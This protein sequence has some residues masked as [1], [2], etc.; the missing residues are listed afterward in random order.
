MRHNR[1]IRLA[2]VV[3]FAVL[4]ALF[5]VVM[6][7]SRA[8]TQSGAPVL[9]PQTG[10]TLGYNFRLAY[11]ALGGQLLFGLPLTEVFI[12]EGMPVQ[13][14]ERVRLEWHADIRQAMISNLGQRLTA[15][16]ANEA[17]FVRA[18]HPG[19]DALYDEV[20]GHAVG[21]AFRQ[22]YER[23]GGQRIFGRPISEEFGE[24]NPQDGNNY[25]V[26]YFERAR[27]EFHPELAWPY[28]VSLG[29]LGRDYLAQH[30]A[31]LDAEQPASVAAAA[32]QGVQ[33]THVS[34]P[35]IGVAV[36]IVERG[37]TANAW[38]VPN[39]AAAHFWPVSAYPGTAGN[40]VVGGHV[41]IPG[42]IF[43]A[44]PRAI[45][46]DEVLLDVGATQRRYVVK[47]TMVVD[48]NALWVMNPSTSE[49]LTLITCYPGSNAA[50]R[51]IVQAVPIEN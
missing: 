44:L 48:S 23:Y 11:D 39:D 29:H 49:M 45:P 40:I 18:Q 50:E 7:A 14:F 10:H 43:S 25:T 17:P 47:Q 15:N 35:R 24:I 41:E 12:E 19:A 8:N 6:P 46:G 32:W 28:T 27:F 36:N 3:L 34:I 42:K 16:R 31:P 26:Q 33:P 22:Y 13:Y 1:R 37:T 21:G 4:G 2:G 38:D 30:P 5:A 9:F 20:S 51:I